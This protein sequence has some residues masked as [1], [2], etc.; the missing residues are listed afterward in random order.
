MIFFHLYQI[1]LYKNEISPLVSVL[2]P[3]YNQPKFFLEALESALSQT[4]QNIEILVGD[5]STNEDI[6]NLIQP[7]LKKYK[8][9][10][11]FYHNGKIPRGG[12][13]NV[14]FLIN[15]CHGEFIN[16]LFH[17]DL[18]YPEK[19]YKMMEYF[20]RDLDD[21]VSLVTSTRDAIDQNGNFIRRQ[22]TWCPPAD[23][24]MPC[25]EVGRILMFTIGNFIGELTTA[26]FRKRDVIVKNSPQEKIY[27]T[28]TYFGIADRIYGDLSTFFNVFRKGGEFVFI[29]ESLSAFRHHS[30][31]N[32]HK[33][34]T[35]VNIPVDAMDFILI[36]WLNDL[37]LRDS[38]EFLY[39]CTK[40][41]QYLQLFV[42]SIEDD[43][44]DELKNLKNRMFEL[45]DTISTGNYEKILD[46][47]V[48][49]LLDRLP[50]DNPIN[51]LVIK[52]EETGLYQKVNEVKTLC[53]YQ[54][55]L[56]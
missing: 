56:E 4:Y 5:D 39:S 27:Y 28:G 33:P 51:N 32:T 36:S 37:F 29:A 18:F 25:E 22:G 41:Q 54:K 17:D 49:F 23:T 50:E 52:N 44:T 45:R 7:Y 1:A 10:K 11:Y 6:K 38:E 46:C 3:T 16:Y 26:I 9:L 47:A 21:R 8:N 48:R 53:V 31:Q 15:N 42:Q 12:R 35:K 14:R 20:T 19:I 24:V 30:D 40:W 13:A 34:W 2:I 55:N 43:D